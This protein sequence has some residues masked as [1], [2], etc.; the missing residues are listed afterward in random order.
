MT[1]RLDYVDMARGIAI[2]LVV[3][4]HLIQNNV[5]DGVHHPS[6]LFI[7]SF[8]MPL[9]FAISGYIGQIVGRPLADSG[10]VFCYIKKKAV[11]LLL[12]LV[13][14]ELVVR[15]FFLS[16]TWNIPTLT[17]VIT[18]LIHP[19]LWF[20]LALFRICLGYS[21]FS[22]ISNRY[23]I[24]NKLWIDL[25]LIGLPLLMGSG[26]PSIQLDNVYLYSLFFFLGV[27]VAKHDSLNR[28]LWNKALVALLIV[29]FCVLVCHWRIEAGVTGFNDFLKLFI[30]T[31][32]FIAIMN[33]CKSYEGC[34][35]GKQLCLWGRYSME[36]YV[37]HWALL[38]F[39]KNVSIEAS[40]V[41]SFWIFGLAV[42][43]ALPIIYS[44]IGFSKIVECST[45]LR[46]ILFGRRK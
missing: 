34:P 12:P 20:L 32:A 43:M 46:L 40:G 42:L 41:N 25:L 27:M 14:W 38:S 31:S 21:L 17:D 26:W 45:Q 4:A 8:H 9:F 10:G 3:M 13:V 6:F 23:N 15:K 24:N 37:A 2:C 11:A 36:I 1:K 16:E 19:G 39:S 18:T 29:V 22:L 7:N 5:A 33:V 30:A 44:C 35:V 28:L